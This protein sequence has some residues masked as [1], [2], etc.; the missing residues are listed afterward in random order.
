MAFR[1][2]SPPIGQYPQ[3]SDDLVNS[4][5]LLLC[6]MDTLYN[7]ALLIDRRDLLNT[8]SLKSG[9]LGAV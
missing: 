8:D 7:A 5:S 1:I 2:P 9:E 3:I 4:H 6:C